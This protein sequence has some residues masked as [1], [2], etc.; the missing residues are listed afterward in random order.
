M[1]FIRSRL[2][3]RSTEFIT[4]HSFLSR[5]LRPEKCTLLDIFCEFNRV[6]CDEQQGLKRT[7][8]S[9]PWVEMVAVFCLDAYYLEIEQRSWRGCF[10]PK[11]YHLKQ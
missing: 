8:P 5:A 3:T 4:L 11:G 9:E 2:L 10:T 6:V 1:D 7:S